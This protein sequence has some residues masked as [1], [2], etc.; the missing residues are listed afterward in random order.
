M[1]IARCSHHDELSPV[2]CRACRCRPADPD[3]EMTKGRRSGR[4]RRSPSRVARAINCPYRLWPWAWSTASA[5]PWWTTS[6]GSVSGVGTKTVGSFMSHQIPATPLS[7][8]TASWSP[9][10]VRVAGLV[11]SG[12]A[13]IPGQTTLWYSAPKNVLQNRSASRALV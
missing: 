3:R 5:S 9:H 2:Q 11:K 10:Q 13:H 8:S 4:S 1:L 12:K 6:S 7:S